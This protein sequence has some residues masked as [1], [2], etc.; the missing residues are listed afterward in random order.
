MDGGTP[1]TGRKAKAPGRTMR[2][3]GAFVKELLNGGKERKE[4]RDRMRL[5]ILTSDRATVGE[6]LPELQAKELDRL[7]QNGRSFIMT[8][9]FA[10]QLDILLDLLDAGCSVT[11]C[12]RDSQN[13][14]LHYL[15]KAREPAEEAPLLT[16]KTILH[17]AL[18]KGLAPNLLDNSGNAALHYAARAGNR[19]VCG[20]LLQHGALANL[21]NALGETALH[22]CVAGT[23]E[24]WAATAALLLERGADPNALDDSGRSP[25]LLLQA[26]P[27]QNAETRAL[28]ACMQ[29]VRQHDIQEVPAAGLRVSTADAAIQRRV[30]KVVAVGALAA[31][32]V[33]GGGAGGG[34]GLSLIH[35]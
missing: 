4:T 27:T 7:D 5:A 24:G 31:Q 10:Y 23:A 14:L 32:V 9:A 17:G 34:G 11:V 1:P 13:T 19:H 35:I 16:L 33:A 18:A 25:L 3:S 15:S 26:Q 21:R 6:L 8:A 22:A 28:V 29:R 30:R 20:V 2:S 12:E